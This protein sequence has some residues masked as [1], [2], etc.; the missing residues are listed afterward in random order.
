MGRTSK[1]KVKIRKRRSLR[2]QLRTVP[3]VVKGGLVLILVG[4]ILG[5]GA[6]AARTYTHDSDTL[7]V[8]VEEISVGGLPDWLDPLSTEELLNP[9]PDVLPSAVHVLDRASLHRLAEYFRK[10]EWVRSVD[11][12]EYV[13]PGSGAPGGIAGDVTLREPLCLVALKST[14]EYYFMDVAGGRLGGPVSRVPESELRF[15]VLYWARHLP[16]RGRPWAEEPIR[17]GHDMASLLQREGLRFGFPH[18]VARIE[19]GGVGAMDRSEILLVTE[20]RVSLN[21]GRTPRSEF[22]GRT[23]FANPEQKI[24]R[25][26]RILAGDLSGTRGLVLNLFEPLESQLGDTGWFNARPP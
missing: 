4:A 10:N 6:Y 7:L 3:F 17:H 19:V 15:P 11:R 20:N 16:A 9:P 18:W 22:S 13:Y 1:R 21:W 2:E 8:R 5:G 26:K 23:Q 25:L 24:A 14:H 12:V